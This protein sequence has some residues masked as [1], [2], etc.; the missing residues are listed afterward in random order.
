MRRFISA[1]IGVLLLL[2]L[3]GAGTAA[4]DAP[5]IILQP[6]SP[7]YPEYSVAMYTVKASGTNLSATWY[8]E[9]QGQ[10]Y[11]I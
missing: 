1:V 8:M 10:T 5:E 11:T 9:W 7:C 4:P 3:V 2:S 6:Q